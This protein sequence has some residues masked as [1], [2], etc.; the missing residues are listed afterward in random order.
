MIKQKLIKN[1]YSEK[2][3]CDGIKLDY[4]EKSLA[5]MSHVPQE[6]WINWH[7]VNVEEFLLT[8][9]ASEGSW[10]VGAGA[11]A[12]TAAPGGGG[13]TS[14]WLP[15]PAGCIG[16]RDPALECGSGQGAKEESS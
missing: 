9:L 1:E 2:L 14:H 11:G 5:W 7:L 6:C 13:V 10:H 8:S 3:Q 12:H 4:L 15:F 16:S